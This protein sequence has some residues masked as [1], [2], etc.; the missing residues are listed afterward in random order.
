LYIESGLNGKKR[1]QSIATTRQP[2]YNQHHTMMDQGYMPT[3]VGIS[4]EM[5]GSH[6]R[7]HTFCGCCCD[8]RRAVIIVNIFMLTCTVISVVTIA[9]GAQLLNA[10]GDGDDEAQQEAA[11]QLNSIPL[12]LLFAMVIIQAVFF[13]FGIMGAIKYTTWMLSVALIGYT[14]YFVMN[15]LSSNF[16]YIG[17]PVLF[18]YPHFVLISE[19]NQGIMTPDNYP[20]EVHSCCCV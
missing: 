12:G 4:Q 3:K 18:A 14:L 13:V 20:N 11:Q 2:K 16:L 15:L 17:L 10:M 1:T 9:L 8:T 7:G 5:G 19:I 6:K